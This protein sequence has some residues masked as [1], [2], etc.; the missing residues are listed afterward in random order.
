MLMS[1]D[2]PGGPETLGTGEKTGEQNISG[3]QESR[4]II[5]GQRE[6]WKAIA[7]GRPER[8]LGNP[9]IMEGT[10]ILLRH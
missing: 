8:L 2:I 10:E 7:F 9:N 1:T 5:G 6:Y 4:V 3:G